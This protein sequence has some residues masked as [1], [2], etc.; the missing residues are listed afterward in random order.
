[1]H[2]CDTG[3]PLSLQIFF[4]SVK[5][6]QF[7][8]ETFTMEF[9]NDERL[10]QWETAIKKQVQRAVKK[11]SLTRLVIGSSPVTPI[12]Q[13]QHIAY[14]QQQHTPTQEYDHELLSPTFVSYASMNR[15]PIRGHYYE[16]SSDMLSEESHS[17]SS[18]ASYSH[19]NDTLPSPPSPSYST[20]RLHAHQLPPSPPQ[21]GCDP[22]TSPSM[23]RHHH[24]AP[25]SP[26]STTPTLFNQQGN[27]YD[28]VGGIRN[29]SQ[30][31]PNLHFHAQSQDQNTT[32]SIAP[33]TVRTSST[34]RVKLHYSRNGI[35]VFYAPRNINLQDLRV[36]AERKTRVNN[37]GGDYLKYRDED[38]D[39][40]T[41]HCDEDIAMAFDSAPSDDAAVHLYISYSS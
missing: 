18:L 34:V 40:I 14:Q 12:P 15:L 1:M 37:L 19:G 39:L 24:L 6:G 8:L 17:S 2:L 28:G 5:D 33:L 38:G 4:S 29:R 3:K 36:L 25:L 27:T 32:T 41:I 31:S 16:Q 22:I 23:V 26:M 7:D 35:F 9:L 13:Q 21:T 10:D 11:R 20:S 30:S